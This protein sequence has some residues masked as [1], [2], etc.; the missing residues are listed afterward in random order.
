M[1]RLSWR[2]L[3]GRSRVRGMRYRDGRRWAGLPVSSRA[4]RLAAEVL[5]PRCLLTDS[6]GVEFTRS[7]ST[8][9]VSASQWGDDGLT[10]FV[11]NDSF[12]I[13]H[14]DESAM[15]VIPFESVSRLVLQGRNQAADELSVQFHASPADRVP[16]IE[17]DGGTGLQPDRLRFAYWQIESQIE[18]KPNRSGL[19]SLVESVDAIESGVGA[20]MLS[21]RDVEW[22]RDQ[23]QSDHRVVQFGSE[24]NVVTLSP[25]DEFGFSQL[26]DLTTDTVIESEWWSEINGGA[27]NDRIT[28]IDVWMDSIYGQSGNDTLI[29]SDYSS[30]LFG[31]DGADWLVG[32]WLYGEAGNDTLDG[33]TASDELHGG[34]G[35]DLL[36]GGDDGDTLFG[37]SGNDTLEGGGYSDSMFGGDG[38]DVL[39]GG[40]GDDTLVGEMGNDSLQGDAGLDALFGGNDFNGEFPS[41]YTAI[42]HVPDSRIDTGRD[43]LRGGDDNDEL[44][45]DA[46]NDSLFGD[47]GEDYV[48]GGLG[49][50]KLDGG[51]DN[52]ELRGEEGNDSLFGGN[53]RD[54]L[55]E[56]FGANLLDGGAGNDLL[57][58]ERNDES[59]P[60]ESNTLLG[61][62]G[63]D[64]LDGGYGNDLLSGGDGRDWIWGYL[65]ND[66]L[67]G[68]AGNDWLHGDEGSD[69]LDGGTE[70]DVLL[71]E[72]EFW[73]NTLL[74]GPGNDQLLGGGGGRHRLE[75]GP[76]HDS[77]EGGSGRET[78]LGGD[79]NDY[80]IGR[81]GADWLDGG[82]GRDK[83]DGE[84][85]DRLLN[86]EISED[87]SWDYEFVDIDLDTEASTETIITAADWTDAGLTVWWNDARLIVSRTDTGEE[88]FQTSD[89]FST[90]RWLIEGRDNANDRLTVLVSLEDAFGDSANK[91]P[92][93]LFDGGGGADE[94]QLIGEAELVGLEPHRNSSGWVQVEGDCRDDGDDHPMISYR[95]V[96]LIL[97]DTRTNQK[98]L[99]FGPDNNDIEFH[100][101]N[102]PSES[103][104]MRVVTDRATGN[105][106]RFSN[107]SRSFDI[108]LG[109]GNDRLVIRD[110]DSDRQFYVGGEAGDD[111]LQGNGDPNRLSGD[112]GNDTLSGLGGEDRLEGGVGDDVLLGGDGDDR[113]S[114][115]EGDDLLLG[116]DGNDLLS[117]SVGNDTL[118]G[119]GGKD[120]LYGD[121]GD[122][123]LNG[124]KG[125]DT[126]YG[127]RGYDTLQGESGNDQLYDA[128]GANR[129]EGGSGDDNLIIYDGDEPDQ[130]WS[131][132]LLG[133]AGHDSLEGGP[134]NDSLSGGD[135][136]DEL[137]GRG[138]N[139]TLRGDA[140]PDD[141]IGDEGN[142]WMDG[143]DARDTLL[144]GP[145][146]DTLLG[147]AANDWLE[148]Y[149][150]DDLLDGG[151]GHDQLLGGEGHDTLRGG[152]G[153]DH[154]GGGDDSDWLD[155]GAG[156]DRLWGNYGPDD[157]DPGDRLLNGEP[158]DVSSDQYYPDDWPAAETYIDWDVELT[159]VILA[160]PADW[161]DAGITLSYFY[162]GYDWRMHV[163]RTDTGEDLI[164]PFSPTNL[165]RYVILGR[166]GDSDALTVDLSDSSQFQN[167][168][169]KGGLGG[170]D[171]LRLVNHEEW[172]NYSDMMIQPLAGEAVVGRAQSSDGN[173]WWDG[174]DSSLSQGATPSLKYSNV[175]RIVCA[176]LAAE[177]TTIQFGDEANNLVLDGSSTDGLW[178]LSDSD[179]SASIWFR[180]PTDY[181]TLI[182]Q[183]GGGNDR[184]TLRPSEVHNEY[185]QLIRIEGGSGD[186]TLIGS[187]GDLFTELY[188]EGGNDSLVG[189]EFDDLLLGGDGNDTLRG[190]AGDDC[191][192]GEDGDDLLFGG[193]G[194]DQLIDDGH[195]QLVEE[196]EEKPPK[197]RELPP[198]PTRSRRE[199]G[200]ALANTVSPLVSD[201]IT[202]D[203][204]LPVVSQVEQFINPPPGFFVLTGAWP[205][206]AAEIELTEAIVADSRSMTPVVEVSEDESLDSAEP[207]AAD[208]TFE[209]FDH[210]DIDR[211]LSDA[212]LLGG[213][214]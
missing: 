4:L 61:Q 17:F 125:D 62:A 196:D 31:G 10:L 131:N 200:D 158:I 43:T 123:L 90:D 79:G 76:G 171:E 75:G 177:K 97:D 1:Q 212:N 193:D 55:R 51:D 40:D 3:V 111:S 209:T 132:T 87:E 98:Y 205:I 12:E 52:D 45:G 69:L 146:D 30:E 13:G 7:G 214:M 59:S 22:V 35:N 101:V 53:G 164:A 83:L 188:G 23:S 174:Y 129:L 152:D 74:G 170:A 47:G 109:A 60:I 25:K 96:E 113:L 173:I 180:S 208:M 134:G 15:T 34:T 150:G 194:I 84:S 151:S 155:G 80:L 95:N 154:L 105:T 107:A 91:L 163:Q 85:G 122:D 9:V 110:M 142:D 165:D 92:A 78:L 70:R 206:T 37:E 139:D 120:D 14:T 136:Q 144:G 116:G 135:G 143:G 162:D 149:E 175:E 54:D 118:F 56:E 202:E 190:L 19:I 179:T 20:W 176:E 181:I 29:A 157:R 81:E 183:A 138:G 184:V 108:F 167:I 207:H 115:D 172:T 65:G 210:A 6:A 58:I 46:G 38:D 99:Q 191:L 112:D 153:S 199:N 44:Q 192:V 100:S 187:L 63:S 145:G 49:N 213:L 156:E 11:R 201:T 8:V 147:G 160:T 104:P 103:S 67:R 168:V 159:T 130:I 186:D 203:G 26:I 114:D 189:S 89:W 127:E 32:S 140:N 119:E 137:D 57:R 50:D 148:A 178:R 73:D 94:L 86:G 93:F 126:I 117:G 48:Y 82:P 124:G 27:G 211:L 5:E 33:T 133:Q 198:K 72:D 185:Y 66:T 204:F 169:F 161:T 166:D 28:A 64:S 2:A 106:I 68:D 121:E 18:P 42:N 195:D 197:L 21:Y 141:I 36:R 41:F 16:T 71:D 39:R 128:E 182:V 102:V 24:N 88:I 77:L